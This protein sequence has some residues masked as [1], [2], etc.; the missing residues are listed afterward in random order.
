MPRI[1]EED[2]RRLKKEVSLVRLC[3]RYKIE[4]KSQG[5]NLVGFCPWHRDDT[6]SFVVTPDKNLWHCMGACDVGGDVFS[7]VMKA[8]NVSFRQAAE[9]VMELAGEIPASPVIK[10]KSGTKHQILVKPD[11][12]L[13]DTE[14]FTHVIDFYHRTFM[15]D[16]KAMKYLESRHCMT[17][18][19]VKM[20]NIGY[21]NRTLGYR[22][23]GTTADGKALKKRLSDLG[24]LRKTGHEHMSGS[25]VFPIFTI[26]GQPVQM[27]GRKITPKLRPGTPYHLYLEQ[28][29]NGIWNLQGIALSPEW[30]LCE[31]IIDALT[32]WGHGFKNVTCCFGKNSFTDDLWKLL[33]QRRPKRIV[34]AFDND[35]AGNKATDKLAPQL[36]EYGVNVHKVRLPK[37]TDINDYVGRLYEKNPGKTETV[38]H[39]LEGFLK[40][41]PVLLRGVSSMDNSVF[42]LAAK[43]EIKPALAEV[44]ETSGTVPQPKA[45]DPAVKEK[46]P[47]RP[48][49]LP[50]DTVPDGSS[51][52]K[53]QRKGEDIEIILGDRTYRVRGL[54]KNQTFDVM[55]VN[56]RVMNGSHYHIDTLDLYNARHRTAFFNLAAQELHEKPEVIKKD[57]GR[58]LLKL[59]D[60][61]DEQIGKSLDINQTKQKSLMTEKEKEDALALLKS[62][63]LIEKI[64]NGF[65][66]FGIV[67][68]T[69]NKLTGFL[70][71]V[72]RKLD[73]PLA[74]LIQS[75][76]ASGKSTL[77]EAIL[78]MVPEEDKIQYSAMTGQSL[79]YLGEKD[80]KHKILDRKSTRLNSSHNSESRMPS[81]A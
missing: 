61:Q 13:K 28:P 14:L 80:I 23:P 73:K 10:T 54:S 5:K 78:A 62:P 19:A 68:E 12:R 50:G 20:F 53:A 76:S 75:S 51:G 35:D 79:F 24:I 70:A 58:V 42:P 46:S 27:Y 3:E 48:A 43:E 15:N 25:V 39:L 26:E 1:P 77:M 47:D 17:P 29:I 8:E 45:I 44:F 2:I 31:C 21:A 9:I 38:T 32:L 74:V 59:E 55:K 34:M 11:E 22:I 6:P 67:G 66:G 57:L 7:L 72:S 81:S 16:P 30:I 36:A 33:K 71:A 60:V 64:V 63:D 41:A 52:I 65:D 40:D 37:D 4:L 69:T 49:G 56:L 18:E